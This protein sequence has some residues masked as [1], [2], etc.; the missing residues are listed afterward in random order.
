MHGTNSQL[1]RDFVELTAKS[2][3]DMLLAEGTNALGGEI[4]SED[5]V[6]TKIGK[7]VSSTRNIVLA[8]FSNV[9]VDRML[10]FLQVASDNDRTLAITSKQA[11]ILNELS[12]DPVLGLPKIFGVKRHV[13]VFRKAKKR[14]YAWEQSIMS[15]VNTIDSE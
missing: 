12:A 9:D 6:K 4:S 10:T 5:E 3:P 11:F 2:V 14:Y 8:N 13:D 15:R 1:T 7:L